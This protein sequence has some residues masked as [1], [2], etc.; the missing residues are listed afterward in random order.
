[1]NSRSDSVLARN[2]RKSKCEV[3]RIVFPGIEDRRAAVGHMEDISRC[4]VEVVLNRCSSKQRIDVAVIKD[5]SEK[6]L[7][8]WGQITYDDVF[9]KEHH[10]KFGQSLVWLPD[11]KIF[12]YYT[13]GQNDAD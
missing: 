6:A 10:T 9:G 13:P 1:V 11:G 8:V 5:G 4:E 2:S 7:F 12:G 3:R